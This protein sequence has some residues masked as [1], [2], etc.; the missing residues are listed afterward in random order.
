MTKSLINAAE[1]EEFVCY[2]SNECHGNRV[3]GVR[4]IKNCCISGGGLSYRTA[5]GQCS[6]CFSKLMFGVQ[7]NRYCIAMINVGDLTS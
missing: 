6:N 3:D 2:S 7:R 1:E 4:E 5:Q